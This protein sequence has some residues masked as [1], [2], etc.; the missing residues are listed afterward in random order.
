MT[1][2]ALF[3]AEACRGPSKGTESAER[4]AARTAVTSQE[5]TTHFGPSDERAALAEPKAKAGTTST[6]SD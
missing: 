2:A 5:A 6:R 1:G 4:A 3:A